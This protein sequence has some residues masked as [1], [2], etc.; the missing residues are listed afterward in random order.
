MDLL[1]QVL[2]MCVTVWSTV[3]LQTLL[4]SR[5]CC[6]VA[7]LVNLNLAGTL[8]LVLPYYCRHS[9]SEW[10]VILGVG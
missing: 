4:L 10:S 7:G 3:L 9:Q 5:M 6:T 1:L 8:T 2:L